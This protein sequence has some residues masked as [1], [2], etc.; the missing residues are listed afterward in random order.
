MT[1]L[2]ARTRL[3]QAS[4]AI[5]LARDL[6]DRIRA[7]QA[8]IRALECENRDLQQALAAANLCIGRRGT[9]GQEGE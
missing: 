5:T 8:Q 3:G 6:Q 4:E 1:D 9:I 2:P 7:Q